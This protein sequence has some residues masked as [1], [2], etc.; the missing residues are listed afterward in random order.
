[1]D[2]AGATSGRAASFPYLVSLTLQAQNASFDTSMMSGAT[3]S[4][5]AYKQAL[6]NALAQ[7]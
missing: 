5:D 1:M 7:F 2:Q 6:T 4:V 3:F